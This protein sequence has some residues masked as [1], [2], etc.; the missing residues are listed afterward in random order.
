[1]VNRTEPT[2]LEFTAKGFAKNPEV[3]GAI[4]KEFINGN[5]DEQGNYIDDIEKENQM[6]ALRNA[7]ES[8]GRL[9]LPIIIE[10]LVTYQNF[11]G[12]KELMK[13]LDVT[14]RFI[15]AVEK[16]PSKLYEYY[17]HWEKHCEIKVSKNGSEQVTKTSIIEYVEDYIE[18]VIANG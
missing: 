12:S 11:G 10:K 1:M 13:F 7:F 17:P 18:G 14:K 15:I 4:F 8:M 2:V 16:E 6:I 3:Y 9:E 5:T